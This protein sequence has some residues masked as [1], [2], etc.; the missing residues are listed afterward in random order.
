MPFSRRLGS[1]V[2]SV[3]CH[4]MRPP[5]GCVARWWCVNV[6]E[7]RVRILTCNQM[8]AYADLPSPFAPRLQ[9]AWFSARL[10]TPSRVNLLEA[11]NV[12][13]CARNACFLA[14]TS[15]DNYAPVLSV[16]CESTPLTHESR[17]RGRSIG[18]G[19]ER[20]SSFT[21]LALRLVSA[22]IRD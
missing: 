8:L 14:M 22:E 20:E 7:C 2:L 21:T 15:S 5:W 6:S 11:C 3:T 10:T 13:S 19:M 17:W 9:A 4:Q 12:P 16:A 18:F 1:D